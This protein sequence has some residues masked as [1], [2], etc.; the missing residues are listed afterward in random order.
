MFAQFPK[1]TL[2]SKLIFGIV[3]V[4]FIITS[5]P[6]RSY[7]NADK[8]KPKAGINSGG[9]STIE[10]ITADLKKTPAFVL[11]Q[12]LVLDNEIT[13][14]SGANTGVHNVNHAMLNKADGGLYNHSEPRGR[15]ELAMSNMFKSIL[16]DSRAI[17][18]ANKSEDVKPIKDGIQ[19]KF[20]DSIKIT[21]GLDVSKLPEIEK[22]KVLSYLDKIYSIV[23]KINDYQ[24]K[25]IELLARSLV[26]KIVNAQLKDLIARSKKDWYLIQQTVL[27]VGETKAQYLLDGTFQE[28]KGEK[29]FNKYLSEN[30][31]KI[32]S[33]DLTEILEGISKEDAQRIGL[34]DAYEPR[35]A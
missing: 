2:F 32:I 30:T 34:R 6:V 16:R 11:P 23:N 17:T 22:N 5:V 28:V 4:S 12:I 26:N 21:A 19:R 15:L 7:A 24:D 8:L 33:Q 1:K 3:A 27:C 13:G 31:K 10:E 18:L 29:V 14:F 9:G 35:W 20:I 25:E